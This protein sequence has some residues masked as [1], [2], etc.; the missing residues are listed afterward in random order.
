[1]AG[2][3]RVPFDDFAAIEQVAA[4]NPNI[5][6]VLFEPIQGEGGI[7]IAHRDYLRALRKLCD[8][9][10]W[11]CSWSTR[12]NAASAVPVPGSRISMPASF[13]MS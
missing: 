10:K 11:G 2:F 13:P 1:V 5:V 3:V 8:E 12:C 4:H 6:A 9:R 7:N